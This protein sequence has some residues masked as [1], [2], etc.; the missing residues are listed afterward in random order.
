MIGVVQPATSSGRPATAT[1]TKAAAPSTAAMALEGSV[2][3]ITFYNPQNGFTVLRLRVRGRRE[4]VAVVGTLPAAQPGERLVL[5]GHWQ[6]D[7]T[8]GA[9]FRPE[10]AEVRPPTGTEDLVRYLGS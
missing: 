6:T 5:R 8:H 3:R 9:Q 1:P 7:P 10:A 4:P 2:E